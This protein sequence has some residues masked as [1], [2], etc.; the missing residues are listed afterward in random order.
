MQCPESVTAQ[1]VTRLRMLDKGSAV[2]DWRL[3]GQLGAFPVDIAVRSTFE[4]D[5][6]TGRV[7]AELQGVEGSFA[8]HA[9]LPR[10]DSG[11]L[12]RRCMQEGCG[13]A[14]RLD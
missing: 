13:D 12:C 3:R 10:N 11:H 1:L 6:I 4:L 14:E 8:L 2:I 7:R 9:E 5:L